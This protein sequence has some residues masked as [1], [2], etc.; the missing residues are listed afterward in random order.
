MHE[1]LGWGR[2]R[3]ALW[4]GV[5]RDSSVRREGPAGNRLALVH[6][7]TRSFSSLPLAG[8]LSDES[9]EVRQPC[10]SMAKIQR[11]ESL[12]NTGWVFLCWQEWAVGSRVERENRS[13]R[14]G[15]PTITGFCL[16]AQ[17]AGVEGDPV[18]TQPGRSLL[19]KLI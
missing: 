17:R 19:C 18:E 15:R 9:S 2:R 14:L 3:R 16:C 13:R 10:C 8:S 4:P 5:H 7:L 12:V 6:P 11:L 1:E